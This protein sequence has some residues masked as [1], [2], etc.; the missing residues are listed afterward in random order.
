MTGGVAARRLRGGVVGTALVVVALG[1]VPSQGEAQTETRP[2]IRALSFEG[3]RSFSD[4]ALANSILTRQTVCRSFILQPFCWSGAEFAQDPAFL[5]PRVFAQDFVRV[6]LF[7]R[8]RGYREVQVDTVIHRE[9]PTQVALT[10]RI[11]E[12]EPVRIMS[13]DVRGIDGVPG[14]PLDANLP[15]SRGDPLDMVVLEAARDTITERLRNRGF[16][17]AD[18]L[19]NL[20]IPTES[21]REAEVE[22][23]VYTGPVARFGEIRVEGNEAVA[24][25]VVRRMLPFQE[26]S[27]YSQEDLFQAQRNLFNLE[28][29]RHAAVIQDLDHLPDSIVPLTVQVNEGNARRV[30]A[31]G[32]WNN[33]DCFTT[34]TRWASRNFMGG[35]RRLVLRGRVSNVLTPTLEES[36][37]SDAGSG[38]FA[39]LNWLTSVEFTQ[40]WI[41]SPRNTF[42]GQAF[43]ERQSVPDVYI[44][45]SLGLTLSLTRTLGRSTPLTLSYQPQLGRLSAAEVFFCTNFLV[46]S[47][48]EIELLERRNRLSPVAL[49]FA[50][51][52]TD[53]PVSPRRGHT[54]AAEAEH[55]SRFTGS[56]FGYERLLAEST[57]FQPLPWDMVLGARARGGWLNAAP[58]RGLEA[59][60]RAS[61]RIAHP[62]KRF[63]AGGAN[64]VRGYAQS[65][66]GPRVMTV[67]VEELI[68]PRDDAAEAICAPGEV[69]DLSCDA[70]A[71]AEGAFES[72]PTGGSAVLEGNLELRFPLWG[73]FLRGV[74]FVDVGQ[75]WPEWGAVRLGEIVAT[76][77]VGLRYGTPIGPIR[78][79]V[80]YRPPARQELPVITSL[81]R[82]FRP[83][84]DDPARRLR[85]TGGDPIDWVLVDELARLTR[86][87]SFEE[88]SGF[89]F[90]RLQFQFSIGH[91]F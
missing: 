78:M 77:G 40:P 2:E 83:E 25:R 67:G 65:Q 74:A 7:Y 80:A 69:A 51:D 82:P 8:Q 66:L 62:Q 39:R 22:F 10:F 73:P 1:A 72:R 43:A 24:D 42:T 59:T 14:S 38:E 52:A 18:V 75:V 32:G 17:H 54:V 87:V 50:Y 45:E 19:R 53:S 31:G 85:P 37:C 5:N 15:V 84:V 6:H 68:F 44:R 4:R 49:S 12:G 56:N 79:D 64:S 33:A 91:A 41:F 70:G 27:L 23:D 55:A 20:F 71:L 60:D 88:A 47:P 61:I 9:T 26:G 63:Y 86:P 76:P 57:F 48:G 36:I 34:E 29:F 11:E 3:N 13:L 21:P 90:Q 16:A 89:S 46:C 30:R 35:A 58:F 81:I 28:I